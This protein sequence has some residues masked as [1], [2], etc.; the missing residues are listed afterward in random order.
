M[1][2]ECLGSEASAAYMTQDPG[3]LALAE[4]ALATCRS[5]NPVPTI[6]E[7]RLL[8]V[9][10]GVHSANHRWEAAIKAYELSIAAGDTRTSRSTHSSGISA[11]TSTVVGFPLT[12]KE[13]AM[14]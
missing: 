8:G 4:G 13:I 11:G 6:T 1:T 5:L 7:S 3:A 2:A 14:D 12:L 10:G 9:L